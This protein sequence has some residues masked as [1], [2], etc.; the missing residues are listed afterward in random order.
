MRPVVF[1]HWFHR[2]RFRC[3]VCHGDLGFE[4]QAGGN[5]INM[6]KIIDGEYCGACHNGNIAWGVENCEL[7]HSGKPGLE[8]HVHGST[9]KSLVTPGNQGQ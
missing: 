7:C 6:L 4:F 2:I 1:P 9:L 8:T 5:D 3:K